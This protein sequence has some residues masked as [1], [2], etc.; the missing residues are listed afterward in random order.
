MFENIN[1]TE[2][3][4]EKNRLKILADKLDDLEKNGPLRGEGIAPVRTIITYLRL[5][6]IENAKN[7]CWYDGDK[8]VLYPKIRKFLQTELFDHGKDPETPPHF[9][10]EADRFYDNR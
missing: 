3:D 6:K 1:P 4:N 8:I 10:P 9:R 5:G 7:C 2:Q